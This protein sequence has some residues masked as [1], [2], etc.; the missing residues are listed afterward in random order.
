M[1]DYA[2]RVLFKICLLAI[3]GIVVV[4][5]DSIA[6]FIEAFTGLSEWTLFSI[7]AVV[8]FCFWRD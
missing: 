7:L 8:A 3:A 2:I 1:S 6:G 5:A 4:V